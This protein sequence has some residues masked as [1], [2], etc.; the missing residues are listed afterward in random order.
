MPPDKSLEK[1]KRKEYEAARDRATKAIATYKTQLFHVEMARTDLAHAL[2]ML[3]EAGL[4]M[5]QKANRCEVLLLM[6][7]DTIRG[8][9]SN[10]EK[11]T[12]FIDKGWV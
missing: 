1:K 4:G 5:S 10:I 2:H 11:A 12:K 9:K 7:D 8:L 3:S 6:V